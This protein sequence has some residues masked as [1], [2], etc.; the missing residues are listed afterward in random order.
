MCKKNQM[1]VK[2]FIVYICVSSVLVVY[3]F[4]SDIFCS[5]INLKVAEM[6]QRSGE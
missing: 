1:S 3:L 2:L 5:L 4:N 6:G